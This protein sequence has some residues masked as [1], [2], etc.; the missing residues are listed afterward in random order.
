M[1][2]RNIAIVYRPV[3]DTLQ[4]YIQQHLNERLTLSC[5][6]RVVHFEPTYLGKMYKAQTGHS[7]SSY[8]LDC[9]MRRAAHLLANSTLR[10]C[11]VSKG[12]GYKKVEY[13]DQLFRDT[14]GETPRGYRRQA[15][16]QRQLLVNE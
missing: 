7:I 2:Q 8:V 1:E 14:F 9:R 16:E 13:F 12:V 3:I 6:G 10:V 15:R 11:D 4:N 5:L